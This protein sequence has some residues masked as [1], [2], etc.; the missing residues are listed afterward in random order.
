MTPEPSRYVLA[1][2]TVRANAR[3]ATPNSRCT[4]LCR[5]LTWKMPSSS[6]PDSLPANFMSS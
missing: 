6:A 2:S 1:P 3:P 4:M 5:M